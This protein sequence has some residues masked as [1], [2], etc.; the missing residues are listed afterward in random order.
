MSKTAKW[1]VRRDV[2]VARKETD[3][4]K[5][6]D[7]SEEKKLVNGDERGG[8]RKDTSRNRL[9]SKSCKGDDKEEI[10]GKKKMKWNNGRME[11]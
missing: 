2:S 10:G 8:M 5:G 1:Q 11:G 7:K 4:E 9:E 6:Q 3:K